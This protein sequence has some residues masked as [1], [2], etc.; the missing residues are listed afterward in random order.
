VGANR[1]QY[2]DFLRMHVGFD[3]WIISFEPVRKNVEYLR[4]RVPTDPKWRVFDWALGSS[5]SLLN[6]NVMKQDYLS[7]FLQ[8]NKNADAMF[9]AGNT[10]DHIEQVSVHRLDAVFA[11]V[12]DKT[13]TQ[14]FYLKLDTQ[15]FDLQVIAGA[16]A[17][18]HRIEGLQT[19]VA[20]QQIYNDMPD[21]FTS[22]RTLN[23]KGF[24]VT[25]MF[26]VTRD[27]DLRVVEFD[28][29]MINRNR[30]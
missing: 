26:P 15:G 8:P 11:T 16:D 7:S 28:C 17:V 3:G 10:V 29:V 4:S 22:I 1:G 21:Y 13:S 12:T 6:F 5:E 9:S 20:V 27:K 23:E 14:H 30:I 25:G 2:R 24:D 19:E 18:L